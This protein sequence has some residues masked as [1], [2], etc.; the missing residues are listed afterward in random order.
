LLLFLLKSLVVLLYKL[1]NYCLNIPHPTE[2][3]APSTAL[4]LLTLGVCFSQ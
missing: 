3:Y 4:R 2:P 1:P